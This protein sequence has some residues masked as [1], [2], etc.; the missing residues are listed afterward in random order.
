[1]LA[2]RLL[3][4]GWSAQ[5]VGDCLGVSASIVKLW[6]T[7]AGMRFV[8]GASGGV[9]RMPMEDSVLGRAGRSYRRLTLRDRVV[10]QTLRDTDP[11]V[12]V[13]EIARRVGVHASTVSRELR[14][15]AVT[16]PEGVGYDAEL[17]HYLAL[18][19]R[20]RA[21]VG[22]LSNPAL[23]EGV[24]SRLNEKFS[25][26]QVAG[27]L[28]LMF[29]HD[30]EMQVSH[31][32]I[33]QALY[34]QG[35]GALRDELRVEKA[36]RS[37]RTGRK[38]QSKLPARTNRPWLDG[39]RLTDRPAEAADRAVAGHW[40]GDL[41]VGPGNSG[42]V[43]LVERRSRLTLLGRLPGTRDSTTVT[44]VL[45]HMI[46]DLPAALK[47]TITWD[48]GTEMAAHAQFT[49]ATGCEVFFCDPHS[50]WQRPS[51]ENTNGL[52]RDFYP[53][54]TNFNTITDE[55]LAHTQHL[56]NIRPRR[57]HGYRSPAAIMGEV[58]TGVALTP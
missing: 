14:A 43:T 46:Q 39:A 51:N 6:G 47:Q 35:R 36:L 22:K 10:I 24:V 12:S 53:K 56:L 44:E 57:I 8:M 41:V 38:P 33:Y 17:A 4:A 21:R 42:I 18:A 27:E 20:S 23:R 15:H 16:H 52:I 2:Y 34:V 25:P 3:I 19:R 29:P 55:D 11:L 5:T 48:Q 7:L 9:L 30:P 50:P 37:G 32:T 13:R 26:Q 31:E 49:I 40:E 28:R 1:M 54:G 45:Q 58:L